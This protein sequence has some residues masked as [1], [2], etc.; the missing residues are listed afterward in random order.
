[1]FT[2]RWCCRCLGEGFVC[3]SDRCDA[4][5][6][7]PHYEKSGWKRTIAVGATADVA[8]AVRVAIVIAIVVVAVP[9]AIV[10]REDVAVAVVVAVVVATVLV[11]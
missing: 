4:S 10:V 2:C 1:M 11:A 6:D 8:I 3:V 7:A 9:V 5:R